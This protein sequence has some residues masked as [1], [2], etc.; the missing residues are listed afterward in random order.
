MA[1]VMG[2][3]VIPVVVLDDPAKADDLGAAM[4]A[5]GLP[6]AEATFR[7]PQAV[8]V[9]WLWAFIVAWGTLSLNFVHTA[10]A[11]PVAALV[12][13][14]AAWITLRPLLRHRRHEGQDARPAATGSG[15]RHGRP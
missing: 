6:I 11:L 15:G 13:V 2:H 1:G 9:L 5:G 8:A 7:S 4:V 14:I 3:R 10:A 12:L